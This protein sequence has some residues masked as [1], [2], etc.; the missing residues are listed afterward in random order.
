MYTWLSN[1]GRCGAETTVTMASTYEA[2]IAAQLIRLPKDRGIGVFLRTVNIDLIAM[3]KF[4]G[5]GR[6][7]LHPLCVTM[8]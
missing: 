7:D 8:D 6:N 1:S 3:N 5:Y 2:G 4:I